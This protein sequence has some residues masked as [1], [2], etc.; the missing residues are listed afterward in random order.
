MNSTN[1][2]GMSGKLKKAKEQF[3][4]KLQQVKN[5]GEDNDYVKELEQT[6]LE[7]EYLGTECDKECIYELK[8]WSS[9]PDRYAAEK[10]LKDYKK[11]VEEILTSV[12]NDATEILIEKTNQKSHSLQ[13]LEQSLKE[14]VEKAETL[15]REF[16]SGEYLDKDEEYLNWDE[17]DLDEDEE[18]LDEDEEDIDWY[19]ADLDED[20]EDIDWDAWLAS[21]SKSWYEQLDLEERL[22]RL[23]DFA[24]WWKEDRQKSQMLGDLSGIIDCKDDREIGKFLT[25]K[26]LRVFT[27][28]F[29]RQLKRTKEEGTFDEAIWNDEFRQNKYEEDLRK[30]YITSILSIDRLKWIDREIFPNTN[31]DPDVVNCLILTSWSAKSDFDNWNSFRKMLYIALAARTKIYLDQKTRNEADFDWKEDDR[32]A[33]QIS[34]WAR[35]EEICKSK[36]DSQFDTSMSQLEHKIYRDNHKEVIDAVF[37]YTRQKGL[38]DDFVNKMEQRF[39]KI[40]DRVKD[41]NIKNKDKTVA[42][43]GMEKEFTYADQKQGTNL[44]KT[45]LS[46]NLREKMDKLKQDSKD[47]KRYLTVITNEMIDIMSA[48][49]NRQ[50]EGFDVSKIS[51]DEELS[52]LLQSMEVSERNI[53]KIM[54]K[55]LNED[56]DNI[57]KQEMKKDEENPEITAISLRQKFHKEIGTIDLENPRNIGFKN[58]NKMLERLTTDSNEYYQRIDGILEETYNKMSVSKLYDKNVKKRIN[59]IKEDIDKHQKYMKGVYEC[60]LKIMDHGYTNDRY[61]SMVFLTMGNYLNEAR[62]LM[63]QIDKYEKDAREIEKKPEEKGSTLLDQLSEQINRADIKDKITDV[64]ENLNHL[65]LQ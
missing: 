43:I 51:E 19:E 15:M 38:N 2:S 46:Q 58:L 56:K 65:E 23:I 32:L 27:N 34:S 47:V 49:F 7:L 44:L 16:I 4:K 63:E 6:V 18:D 21:E 29:Y 31:V 20:E 36:M 48:Y 40:S 45:S 50:E 57:Q 10:E 22:S 14:D 5:E 35:D 12:Y 13:G 33:E 1:D 25:T 59:E 26:P 17:E 3:D 64:K 62:I 53:T 9:W 11:N 41:Y 8:K 60:A 52:G 37:N 28:R 42:I 30:G 54:N 61:S 24:Y 39:K 55:L